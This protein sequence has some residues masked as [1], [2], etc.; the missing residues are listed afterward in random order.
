VR[1]ASGAGVAAGVATVLAGAALGAVSSTFSGGHLTIGSDGADAIVVTCSGGVV[2]V[3]GSVPAGAGTVSCSAVTTLFV[4]G[5]PGANTIDLSGVHAADFTGLPPYG[6]SVDG[7]AGDDTITGSALNDTLNG[8]DGADHIDGGNGS[9]LVYADPGDGDTVTDSGTGANDS[10]TFMFHPETTSLTVTVDAQGDVTVA[11]AIASRGT[12]FEYTEID[13]TPG[14][15]VLDASAATVP[16]IIDASHG[17]NDTLIGGS[18]DDYLYAGSGNDHLTGGGGND[19]LDGGGGTNTLDGGAGADGYGIAGPGSNTISDSGT[20]AA[21]DDTFYVNGTPGPD[22]ITIGSGSLTFDGAASSFSGIERGGVSVSYGDDVVDASQAT[23]GLVLLGGAG[24]DTLTGGSADDYLS[25]GL[26]DDTLAGGAGNDSFAPEGG[27]DSIV[28]TSGSFDF[29]DL[30]QSGDGATIDLSKEAG[31]PQAVNATET[32]SITGQ[33][34]DLVGTEGHDTITGNSASNFIEGLDGSDVVNAGG[35]DDLIQVADGGDAVDGQDGSDSYFVVFGWP[36]YYSTDESP[37]SPNGATVSDT[38]TTGSD[39]LDYACTANAS[40]SGTQLSVSGATVSYAGVETSH[41]GTFSYDAQFGYTGYRPEFTPRPPAASSGGSSSSSGSAGSSASS[42][43]SSAS[44][45]ASSGAPSSSGAAPGSATSGSAS[46]AAAPG[47]AGS[48][49]VGSGPAVV[50]TVTWQAQSFAAPVTVKLSEAPSVV[51]V[52]GTTI[53]VLAV[54]L[55]VTA[56]DGTPVTTFSAPL[57]LSFPAGQSGLTPAFSVDGV[58][59]TSMPELRSNVLPPGFR[60]GWYRDRAGGIHVL[61]LHAT[62]FALLSERAQAKPEF[63]VTWSY[64]HTV[65]LSQSHVLQVQLSSTLP[66][67]AVAVLRRGS[68]VVAQGAIALA[69]S[70]TTGLRLALSKRLRPGTY[71]LTVVVT[72]GK[73][74]YTR[75]VPVAIR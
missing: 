37:R 30:S 49:T 69:S 68:Q 13:G 3:N 7:G 2:Q 31:E 50:T 23:I 1:W 51:Q 26:G 14:D 29:L 12:G 73:Q 67:A 54:A 5:G 15:D 19:S 43:S 47:S 71:R 64:G 74:R 35:G 39:S 16:V 11:G 65:R 46:Q 28:D 38:G 8:G 21:S 18:A 48:V 10:D 27:T 22:A 40:D 32:L 25:G 70:T 56:A 44:S 52:A 57:E 66:G 62:Y 75:V 72:A 59:W 33:I 17:G 61:T 6:I 55:N 41:C 20:D 9:D 4:R 45:G 60:D 42:G 36:N 53:G 63:A 58:A 24:N 34:E